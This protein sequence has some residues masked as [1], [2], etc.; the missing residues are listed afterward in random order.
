MQGMTSHSNNCNNRYYG[1]RHYC[2]KHVSIMEIAM[3]PKSCI[4][5][6]K[7]SLRTF[8]DTFQKQILSHFM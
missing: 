5:A 4:K 3:V 7:V 2:I 1:N 6:Y 8:A